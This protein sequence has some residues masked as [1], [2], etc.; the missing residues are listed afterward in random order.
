[1]QPS[2]S[3]NPVTNIV[4]DGDS[5]PR[6]ITAFELILFKDLNEAAADRIF[7]DI[8]EHYDN[9]EAKPCGPE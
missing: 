5:R 6:R 1:M 9:K 7:A 4:N 2:G 3:N 8:P